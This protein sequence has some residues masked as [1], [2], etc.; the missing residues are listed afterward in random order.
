MINIRKGEKA[1]LPFILKLIKELADYENALHKVHINISDL[2]QDGFG[3]KPLFYFLVAEKNNKI[4]GMALYYIKYSTW[5][6]KC[7]FLEDFIVQKEFR[8]NNVGKLLFDNIIK[9]AQKN[10]MNRIMWQVLGWNKLAIN[11]YK[12]YNANISDEWL[13]GQ[14]NKDQIVKFNC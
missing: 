7:L 2:E 10:Q 6:G 9:I 13:N 3:K 12:K 11:F 8:R 1:D 4:I 5:E 14:L